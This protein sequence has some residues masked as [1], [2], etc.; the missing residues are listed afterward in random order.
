[1]MRIGADVVAYVLLRWTFLCLEAAG[2]RPFPTTQLREQG[3]FDLA[4]GWRRAPDEEI[5][6]SSYRALA[7]PE[8]P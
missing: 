6:A 1:M 5:R 2:G 8:G 4:F 3:S 7:P